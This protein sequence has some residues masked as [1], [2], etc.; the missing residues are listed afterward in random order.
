MSGEDEPEFLHG[1]ADASLPP[2]FVKA[3]EQIRLDAS[4]GGHGLRAW[5][6][7]ADAASVGQW[8]LTVQS[9]QIP[10]APVGELYYP[11]LTHVVKCA[12]GYISDASLIQ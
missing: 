6:L 12:G 3:Y 1:V 10:R 9:A 7:H 2:E 8:S 5:A 11:I 4:A